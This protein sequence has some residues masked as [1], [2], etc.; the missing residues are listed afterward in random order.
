M[1]KTISITEIEMHNMIKE[2]LKKNISK[3]IKE[4][5]TDKFVNFLSGLND[6]AKQYF[7]DQRILIN[8]KEEYFNTVRNV[9]EKTHNQIISLNLNFS[10]S[11]IE[12]YPDVLCVRYFINGSYKWDDDMIDEID[13]LYYNSFDFDSLEE[14][15]IEVSFLDL[16]NKGSECCFELTFDFDKIRE[17]EY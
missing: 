3:I 17:F 8:N 14:L 4:N 10:I 12:K 13:E 7:S 1:N 6:T 16:R 15:G 2:S 5:K 9:L 11:N